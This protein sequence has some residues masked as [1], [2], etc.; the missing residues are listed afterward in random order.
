MIEFWLSF[1]NGAEKLRLPVP[2]KEF[3]IK[4]GTV[5][6]VVNIHELG[7]ILLIGKRK[8]KSISLQTYFPIADDGVAQYSGFPSP[9]ACIDM[10]ARWRES[11]K[12]IRLL[13]VGDSFKINESM[14]I[15]SFTPGQKHGPQDI[16]FTMDLTEY[17][18][19]SRAV[20]LNGATDAV[21][22]LAEYTGN[23]RG[24]ERDI[25]KTWTFKET[26]SLWFVARQ[27]YGDGSRWNEIRE[28]NDIKDELS[29]PEGT[30]L[31]L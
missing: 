24:S 15:E 14:V 27:A 25:P 8:L 23:V 5:T 17:R 6:T 19:T 21:A 10:I 9:S 26:D 7:E 1:N 11:S 13:I 18:F 29:I 22:L 20:D 2:P 12:P 31:L 16:Y 4:T 3:E 30:V 28:K